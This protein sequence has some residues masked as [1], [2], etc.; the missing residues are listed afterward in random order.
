MNDT[1]IKMIDDFFRANTLSPVILCIGTD[2]VSGDA[3]GPTVGTLLTECFR[4]PFFVY[5]TLDRPVTAL[6]LS[7]AMQFISS[8]HA[9][10]PVIAVDCALGSPDEVGSIRVVDG[11][12]RAGAGVGKSLPS[13]GDISVT[14]VVAAKSEAHL[15]SSIPQSKVISLAIKAAALIAKAPFRSCHLY[16]TTPA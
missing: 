1:D 10:Q 11:P 15:L 2:K 7:L 13:V 3:L 4:V 16:N 14:A 12:I 5:G 9:G 8:R 6:N